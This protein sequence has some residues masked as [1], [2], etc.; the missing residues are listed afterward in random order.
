MQTF[1]NLLY[2]SLGLGIEPKELTFTQITICGF[3]VFVAALTMMR[4]GDRR[5]LARKTA[6][7]TILLVVLASVLARAV[8]GSAAFFATI[9]ASFVIVI[10]HRLIAHVAYYLPALGNF[11]KG[12]DKT[13]VEDGHY[14]RATMRNNCVSEDDLIED[15]RLSAKVEGISK[16]K[17]ARLERSGDL[18]FILK[19]GASES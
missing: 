1:W 11:I 12:C 18:S 5:A 17:V 3:V 8:N 19:K 6:F 16:V 4:I 10:F 7:D 9:G 14:C 13:L 2:A 15:L